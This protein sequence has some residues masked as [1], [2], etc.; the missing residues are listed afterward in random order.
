MNRIL[1]R[2][3]FFSFC[4]FCMTKLSLK[5][6][7]GCLNHCSRDQ[8]ALLN[9]TTS[10]V[11]EHYLNYPKKRTRMDFLFLK[12]YSKP[13]ASSTTTH[14]ILDG[15]QHVKISTHDFFNHA[16]ELDPEYLVQPFSTG[17]SPKKSMARNTLYLQELIALDYPRK[18][19]LA[20][21]DGGDSIF[22]RQKHS[23][24][25]SKIYGD[26]VAGYVIPIIPDKMVDFGT[27]NYRP[28][29]GEM[30]TASLLHLPPG[31]LVLVY[32]VTTFQELKECVKRGVH[33]V[34]TTFFLDSMATDGVAIT[35]HNGKI[36]VTVGAYSSIKFKDKDVSRQQMLEP[37][38]P[39]CQCYTCLN[40]SIAYMHHLVLVQ[41]LL[42][43][44]LL[45]LH[46]LEQLEQFLNTC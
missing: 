4:E 17:N 15:T 13:T 34:D 7:S 22:D 32:G 19:I 38:D 39:Q 6:N 10:N 3:Q 24:L 25:I 30:L 33:Y 45:Q 36:Q 20:A 11:M 1:R 26:K 35:L 18:R 16:V 21:L 2:E 23:E 44:T 29:F 28:N 43:L 8:I 14:S 31:S 41:D 5:L 9:R 12:E 46:N 37:I 42:A 27:D 40:H